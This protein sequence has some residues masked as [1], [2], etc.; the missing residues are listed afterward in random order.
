MTTIICLVEQLLSNSPLNAASGLNEDL[1]SVTP[2]QFLLG[3]SAMDYPN[4]VFNSG[5]VDLE[6]AFW[7]HTKFRKNSWRQWIKEILPQLTTRKK[8]GKG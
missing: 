8:V 4:V 1:E 3:R 7:A 5:S 6:K 2:N